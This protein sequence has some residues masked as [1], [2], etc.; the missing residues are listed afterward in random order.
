MTAPFPR[1]SLRTRFAAALA[2][3]VFAVTGTFGG[4]VGQHSVEQ[5]RER[6]GQ[7]LATDALR[8]ADRL[9]REMADRARELTLVS[10]LDAM[11][12]LHNINAVQSIIDTL[13]RNEPDYLWLAVTDLQGRVVAATDGSLVGNDLGILPDLREQLRGRVNR[14]DDP[15]RIARPGDTRPVQPE[16]QQ[17]IN[18][19]RPIRA[20]DGTVEGV[21]VAQL[22]REWMRNVSQA[23]L[24]P[25]EDGALHRQSFIISNTDTVLM[26][27]PATIGTRL[28]LP[29]INRARAGIYGWSTVTWP[30]QHPYITATNFASGDGPFPGAGS[31]PMNWTVLVREAEATAFAPAQQ[32]EISIFATG[33]ALSLIVAVLG[34]II[35]GVIT[36]PLRQ[37]ATAADRLCR[38]ENVE[39]PKI[40]TSTEV[41]TLSASLRALV[42]TLTFKQVRLD[43]LESATQHDP[44]TG[45]LNRAGLQAWLS[46]SLGQARIDPTGLL[47]LVGDLDG[48][49]QVNDTY[50]HASGDQLLQEVARR[51]QGA[52]R[53]RDAV[54]RMGGDEFVLVLHAPLGLADRLAVET[55]QRVW[56]RVTEPY[57][58]AGETITIGLSLGGA[59]WPE[60]DRLLD[61]VLNKADAALYAAKRG[62]KGRIVFHREPIVGAASLE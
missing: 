10:G 48:F 32:L 23:L 17:Q 26:G 57:L 53:S 62:G 54:A 35:A 47:V 31:S 11:R 41:E 15:M 52:V 43:E 38:G 12:D 51:L 27:P 49:K 2:V 45:L 37:I 36:R 29:E 40:R 58:I 16:S 22:S 7:S 24:T 56:L 3:L 5:L 20:A 9:N 13:R 30:D 33:F 44:L 28:L 39:M 55:A 14:P 4:V 19:S 42:A 46:R 60:D 61:L 1:L 50:G 6:I 21:I 18:I 25:D 59:G 34:W 8:M